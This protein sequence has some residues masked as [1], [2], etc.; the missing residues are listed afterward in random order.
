MTQIPGIR[1]PGCH[2]FQNQNRIRHQTCHLKMVG[3]R[4]RLHRILR[5]RRRSRI[6]TRFSLQGVLTF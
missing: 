6:H 1:T 4:Y 3:S 2:S 5:I